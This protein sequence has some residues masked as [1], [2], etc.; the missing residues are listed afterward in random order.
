MK[1]SLLLALAL[2]L[3]TLAHADW[4]SNFQLTAAPTAVTTPAPTVAPTAVKTA[5]VVAPVAIPLP[6]MTYAFN[7]YVDVAAQMDTTNTKNTSNGLHLG[8]AQLTVKADTSEGGVLLQLIGGDNAP[9]FGTVTSNIKQAYL[10]EDWGK[11]SVKA[12]KFIGL[13]GYE[14]PDANVNLNYSHSPIFYMEPVY[15]IGLLANY[16]IN[17][18]TNLMAYG[19][20]ENS[21]DTSLDETKDFGASLQSLGNV[22]GVAFNWYRDNFKTTEF[23]SKD[24]LN[25]YGYVVLGKYTTVGLEYFNVTTTNAGAAY[26]NMGTD[27][28]SVAARV[29]V[30]NNPDLAFGK[31]TNQYTLTLKNK[32]G[33]I[34]NYLEVV[35]N[36]A[37]DP[38]YTNTDGL[39]QNNQTTVVLSSVYGF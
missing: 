24:L 6:T 16:A 38:I 3:T 35:T 5:V 15:N 1:K 10:H 33:N 26:L 8:T 17:D 32:R 22:A 7:G 27:P 25:A 20:N 11:F 18:I 19:A 12:G 9:A 2:G 14:L 28:F 36:V 13:L 39:A 30:V 21:L 23:G 31:T 4:T 37:S 29:C 34:S